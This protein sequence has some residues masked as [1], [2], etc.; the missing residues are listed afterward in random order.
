MLH[1]IRAELVKLVRRPTIVAA[2]GLSLVFA[3][4]TSLS[5][6]LSAADG[7]QTGR[8]PTIDSLSQ[9]GGGTQAFALG[10]SV[11]GLLVLVMF[12]ANVTGEVSRGTFRTLLM[13]EPGRLRLLAGKMTALLGFTAVIVAL[14]AVLS[15]GV[16]ALIA[17][18]QDISTSEWF[19]LDALREGLGDY[20]T[21]L[22][23]VGAWAL[24]GMALGIILRST[25]IALGVAVAWAGPFEHIT[26]DSW[27]TANAWFPG[28]LLEAVAAGGTDQ[29]A[30]S[31]ALPLALAYVAVAAAIAAVVFRRRDVTA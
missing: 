21:G 13:R 1:V 23:T 20:G 11:A 3:L 14:A 12:V 30:L 16:S 22:L 29:V 9:A 4:V 26:V 10:I 19:G 27:S 24:F 25:P 8:A 5:V 28:L 31:R 2:A 18:S 15:F 6:L 17:P 7:P